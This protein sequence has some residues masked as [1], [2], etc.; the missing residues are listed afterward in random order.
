MAQGPPAGAS[1][2]MRGIADLA[3][4]ARDRG[5][6]VSEYGDRIV[7]L[8]PPG[9]TSGGDVQWLARGWV[10]LV[11][12]AAPLAVTEAN[13]AAL[14]AQVAAINASA[15]VPGFVVRDAGVFCENHVLVE[16]DGAISRITFDRSLD[17]LFTAMGKHGEAL[18]A[19]ALGVSGPE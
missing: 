7:L 3:A 16:P 18:R 14:I 9:T 5:F 19:T 4:R 11:R 6:M 12:C 17:M 1:D 10:V 15:A 8:G 13:R 2:R